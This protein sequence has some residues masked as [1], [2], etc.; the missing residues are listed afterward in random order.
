MYILPSEQANK[1]ANPFRISGQSFRHISA[2]VAGGVL[3][4]RL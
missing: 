3:A 1:W 2:T 4:K